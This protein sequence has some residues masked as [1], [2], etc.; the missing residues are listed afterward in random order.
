V[1][2]REVIRLVLRDQEPRVLTALVTE[3]QLLVAAPPE[4]DDPLENWAMEATAAPVDHDDPVITRLFPPAYSE[5]DLDAEYR[6]LTETGLRRAKDADARVVAGD[7]AAMGMAPFVAIPLDHVAPW[8]RTLNALRLAL[9]MRLEVATADDA[10]ALEKVGP[11]DP[12]ADTVQVYH[13]LGYL[14]EMLLSAAEV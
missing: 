12:R 13:W 1:K 4:A 10:E 8:L 14:L 5:P 3:L 7:I 9:A 11:D 6:R 2:R